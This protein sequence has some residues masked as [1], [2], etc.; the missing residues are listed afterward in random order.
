MQHTLNDIKMIYSL[1]SDQQSREIWINK[2]LF[3]ET[4]DFTFWSAVVNR[5][6]SGTNDILK[7]INTLPADKQIVLYGAGQD[8][9]QLLCFFRNDKRFYGFCSSTEEKQRDGYL[10]YPVI[11]PSELLAS[12][13]YS[14]VIA[15]RSFQDEI[16]TSLIDCGYPID[17]IYNISQLVCYD[18]SQYFVD[19][20]IKF[21]EEEVFVDAGCY[22]L[23]TS[24]KM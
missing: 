1:L 16:Y 24:I 13:N 17:L 20:L 7:W 19:D 12:K 11:S 10:G 3:N 15:T 9:K 22:D 8:G 5:W 23:S 21:E 6:F 18:K 2:M 14:V 4:G